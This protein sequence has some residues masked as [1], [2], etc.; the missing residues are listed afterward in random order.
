MIIATQGVRLFI[1]CFKRS[2][3]IH[4]LL[5]ME[6]SYMLHIIQGVML[7]AHCSLLYME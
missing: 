2:V 1:R 6:R 5:Y 3:I 7:Y 4:S